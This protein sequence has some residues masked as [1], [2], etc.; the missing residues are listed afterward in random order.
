M[1]AV[2]LYTL[3]ML[4]MRQHL[5]HSADGDRSVVG[6]STALTWWSL[7]TR[8]CMVKW[9]RSWR[10]S[11]SSSSSTTISRTPGPLPVWRM[12]PLVVAL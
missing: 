12:R 6:V 2:V 4:Q 5:V 7:R 10:R 8:M 1:V 11:N 9:L 3:Q